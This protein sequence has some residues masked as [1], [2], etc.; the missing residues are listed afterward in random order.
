MKKFAPIWQCMV[1]ILSVVLLISS[2][3]SAASPGA[4]S[5][6]LNTLQVYV[7]QAIDIL[8][9][10]PR[11]D[12]AHQENRDEKIWEVALKLFDFDI[13]AKLALG[14]NRRLFSPEQLDRFTDLFSELL[15]RTYVGKLQGEYQ[16]SKI[17]INYEGQDYLNASQTRAIVKTL[18]SRDDV[19]TPI[20]YSM[21]RRD[22]QWVVY[23]IKVEQVS[24]IQNYREQFDDILFKESP[25]QLMKRLKDKLEKQDASELS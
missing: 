21:R 3:A 13:I 14:R 4:K 9:D 1:I 23:D 11:E 20:D 6:P 5:D 18:I 17:N 16:S 2:A 15:K 25:E 19:T 12:T 10:M 24:L 7:D 22:G 8:E